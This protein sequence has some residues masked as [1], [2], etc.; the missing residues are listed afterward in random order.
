M[1]DYK[2]LM[3]DVVF[4]SRAFPYIDFSPYVVCEFHRSRF[5]LM[6]Q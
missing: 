2:R 4:V 6:L 1:L 5:K 3:I